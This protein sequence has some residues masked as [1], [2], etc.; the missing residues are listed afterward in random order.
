MFS[1]DG[2]WVAY[3]STESGHKEVYV[4]S[5]PDVSGKWQV[6][7]GYGDF[8]RWRADG[9]ELFFLTQDRLMAAEISVE[10]DELQVGAI[11][12]LFTLRW[13]RGT[14]S[15]YDVTPDGQQFLVNMWEAAPD[16]TPVT[17]VVNWPARMRL[18]E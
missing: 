4:T 11:T 17:I 1:P 2:R 10:G 5:Y 7:N 16:A 15:V 6:S 8:P 3:V 18:G 13:P 12:P 9:R 14:R